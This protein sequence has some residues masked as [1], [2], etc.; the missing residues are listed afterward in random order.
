M[1][2]KRLFA[3]LL[4]LCITVTALPFTGLTE[5]RAVSSD[6]QYEVISESDK[7]CAITFYTGQATEVEIPSELDG[8]MV[9]E[10]QDTAFQYGGMITSV[11]IPSSITNIAS[12]AFGY[13]NLYGSPKE[14]RVAKE[15]AQYSSKDGVLFNK[16][17]SELIFYPVGKTGTTYSVPEGTVKVA[18]TAFIFCIKLESVQFPSSVTEIGVGAFGQCVSLTQ[19]TLPENLRVL[20]DSAFAYCR[21]LE[22]MDFS[23]GLTKIGDEAFSYCS[24][25]KSVTLPDSLKEIGDLAFYGTALESIYLPA[26]LERIGQA[27]KGCWSLTDISV[28]P[29]NAKFSSL[30]GVLF[31]KAQT[32]LLLYP[33][34]KS[35]EA[36]TVPNT[37]TRI[38]SDAFSSNG[39]L[40]SI[41]VPD[42]V[43]ELG[44]AAFSGC[45]ALENIQ[46]SRQLTAIKENTFK[47]C[48]ALVQIEIPEN[49]TSIGANA[50]AECGALTDIYI[51]KNV[52]QIGEGAFAACTALESIE[53]NEDN[54]NYCSENGILFNRNKTT[55]LKY[56]AQK[57]A[58]AYVVPDSV[59]TI[60]S[61]AFDNCIALT[62][63]TVSDNVTSIGEAAFAGCAALSTVLIPSNVTQIAFSAFAAC[64]DTLVLFGAVDSYAET[65]AGDTSIMFSGYRV[66]SEE[67][68][69]CE[70][71]KWA[72][73]VGTTTV[74]I[75]EQ[76]GSY[77]VTSIG[78]KVFSGKDS[79][80]SITFP[81]T[82]TTIHKDAFLNCKA[83]KNVNIPENIKT[84]E[85]QTFCGC[86][87]LEN[88][89]IPQGVTSIEDSAFYGCSSLKSIYIPSSVTEIG[90]S[91][92]SYTA[93]LKSFSV[94]NENPNYS[95]ENGVLFNKDKTALLQYPIGKADTT[96]IIPDTVAEIAA[97][98]FADC[99]ALESVVIPSSVTSIN[100]HAFLNC[101]ALKSVTIPGSVSYVFCSFTNCTALEKV[102]V[103]NG[104]ASLDGAF[105]GCTAL[106]SIVL[107]RSMDMITYDTFEGCDDLTIYGYADNYAETFAENFDIPF[108]Y[109]SQIDKY[110]SEVRFTEENGDIADA[111]DYR[112]TSVISDE[113]WD[114]FF[115]DKNR[116][117]TIT[118]VGFVAANE[119]HSISLADAQDAV[120]TGTVL[121]EGWKTASTSYIQK[122]S[123]D[124]D[125]YFGCIIKDIKHSEQAED[126]VCSAY[127]AYTDTDGKTAYVWYNEPTVAAVASNYDAVA[128]AWR[129]ANI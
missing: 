22:S 97:S 125:A 16:D 92:F 34:C 117:I 14:I 15:N 19:V 107:P 10:I 115:L 85:Y 69:T 55:L 39:A 48:A 72:L 35:D 37:V 103:E 111:F 4:A 63:V 20:G 96:Y 32:G 67:E 2:R 74:Q 124:A 29:E 105:S 57:P 68:K 99:A 79:L 47:S 27:L 87:S 101:T 73:P 49:V 52:T 122:V 100:F 91:A 42:S 56:P 77:T 28:S 31:D 129:A 94:D 118:A 127:I 102:V 38:E 90:S 88:I 121:P 50:F 116:D 108:V 86:Q 65:F 60:D 33:M 30:D 9:T 51:P 59:I 62:S 109:L 17:Q 78:E 128:D 66:L 126:I 84:I 7:T 80:V 45:T 95:S 26:G 81:E 23:D 61:Y 43:T 1:I 112:L 18:D 24:S 89:T 70:I 12:S 123:D 25:L 110:K 5:A 36:Y 120:E 82:I 104:V 64:S 58:S 44:D 71:A 54:P 6:F 83:L 3:I 119:S 13:L 8:Y 53:V 21:S 113:V 11:T 46:L 106:K 98:A 75:P 114:S 40:E 41:V 76:I 93:A